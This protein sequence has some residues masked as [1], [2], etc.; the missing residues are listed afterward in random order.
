MQLE[1]E[2]RDIIAKVIE[3]NKE[4]ILL[5]T[6][7]IEDLV[8]D[9]MQALEIMVALDKKYKINISESEIPK[10]TSL[11]NILKLVNDLT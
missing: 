10:M 4:R 1:S 2:I 11:R 8:A 6:H 7:L 9:S 3:V 5:D